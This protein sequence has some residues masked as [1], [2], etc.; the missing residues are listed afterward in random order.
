MPKFSV[1]V[2]MIFSHLP[3]LERLEKV[4]DVGISAFEFWGWSNKDVDAIAEKKR[5]LGLTSSSF[6]V[7]PLSKDPMYRASITESNVKEMFVSTVEA[8]VKVAKKLDCKK[9]MIAGLGAPAP[10]LT[11]SQ[12]LKNAI[13]NLKA[14]APLL[15]ES[16][17]T[18]LI[19]PVNPVNHKG[20]FLR[21]SAEGAYIVREVGSP[22]VKMLYDFYHQQLTEGNLI[23]NAREYFDLIGFFHVG[24]VPGRHEPGTGEINYRN[25]FRF[26]DESGYRDY[27]SLEFMPTDDHSEA[28]RK[29]MQMASS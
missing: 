22:N 2:E 14:V 9:L 25:I 18:L 21:K 5:K 4:K 3:F 27:I 7:D 26:L 20:F 6:V 19:E 10:D 13:S 23:G 16:G 1:C 15:E 24:D 8:S 29:T 12:Q 17:V 11:R 28:I